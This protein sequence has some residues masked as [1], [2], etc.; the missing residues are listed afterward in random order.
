VWRLSVLAT[1]PVRC[2]PPLLHGVRYRARLPGGSSRIAGE[3]CIGTADAARSR[4]GSA[5]VG[6]SSFA[7]VTL[8][9]AF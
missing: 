2:R 7:T 4:S 8:N 6:M 5:A 9:G 3:R 1:T